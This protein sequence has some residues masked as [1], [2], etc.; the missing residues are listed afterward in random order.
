MSAVLILTGLAAVAI[1]TWR[2][3]AAARVAVGP[4]VHEGEPTRTLIDAGRPVLQRSRVRSFARNVVWAI[5]WLAVAMYGLLLVSV[6]LAGA[7]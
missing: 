3:Y 7:S 5:A 4:L 6:G 2:G 1:G